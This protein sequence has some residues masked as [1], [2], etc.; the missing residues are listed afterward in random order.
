M[1][2][3][4]FTDDQV[5]EAGKAL[6]QTGR[7]IT[8]F[9]LRSHLGSGNA[10]RLKQIWDQF[11]ASD[12]PAPAPVPDL[13]IEVSSRLESVIGDL[14]TQITALV[15]DLHKRAVR[16]SE[17]RVG[18]LVRGLDEQRKQADREL[19]DAS[20]TVDD[21]EKKLAEVNERLQAKEAEFA[22]L[23]NTAQ[24]QAV[25]LSAATEKLHAATDQIQ[26]LTDELAT[27]RQNALNGAKL[28][29]RVEALEQQNSELLAKLSPG[30]K[31]T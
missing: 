21:V 10:T 27:V 16:A 3:P 4:T 20:M 8:G 6:R 15:G 1:R 2:P 30:R 17:A 23:Q 7:A 19:A 5:I 13:P 29:G 14:G 26:R 31:T 9:A 24:S 11:L 18:E 28:Q 22:T 25:E 12:Q